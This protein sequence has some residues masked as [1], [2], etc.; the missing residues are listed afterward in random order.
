MG[1]V[2]TW[3]EVDVGGDAG[4][5][6]GH[7]HRAGHGGLVVKHLEL[8]QVRV[9]EELPRDGTLVPGGTPRQRQTLFKSLSHTHTHFMHQFDRPAINSTNTTT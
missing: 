3:V 6:E 8:I 5:D 1:R 4:G 7:T 9:T 2:L